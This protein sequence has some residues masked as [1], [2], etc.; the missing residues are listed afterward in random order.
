MLKSK[1]TLLTAAVGFAF[2][3]M[4][5]YLLLNGTGVRELGCQPAVMQDA[6]K[7]C[8]DTKQASAQQLLAAEGQF[9]PRQPH[10]H[11]AWDAAIR[12]MGP[13][14]QSA[15]WNDSA[16]HSHLNENIFADRLKAKVRIFC[17]IMTSPGNHE[18]KAVHLKATWVKRCNNFVFMSTKAD[19]SLPSIALK[20]G[21]GRDNLWAKTKAAFRYLYDHHL[22]DYDFFLKADDDTY[23]VVENLR[24]MLRNS[25]PDSGLYAGRRFKPFVRQGYMSGGA[26]YVL[27]R[28][29]VKLF[30]E[31]GLQSKSSKCSPQSGGAEDVQVGSCLESV[32][33]KVFD[34]VDELGRER[35]H[36][37][38]PESHLLPN[39]IPKDN[40]LWHYNYHPLKTGP[41][42][43]SDT[44]VSFHYVSPRLMYALEFFVY[45]LKP[46]GVIHDF[47]TVKSFV[48]AELKSQFAQ[49]GQADGKAKNT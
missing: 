13:V 25:D 14:R 17:W 22:K 3:C 44:T 10:D 20:V 28:E 40:W 1:H 30:I 47:E 21:E 37:F 18:S 32:G 35:F 45:H 2:G 34:S 15:L 33:V 5:S 7:L 11:A 31:R 48:L 23:A 29:A 39:A 8:H 43:C 36:P 4:L 38:P 41:D 42:C 46:Y 9:V 27:S 12:R 16:S 26:G 24:Y 49:A 19:P 6:A